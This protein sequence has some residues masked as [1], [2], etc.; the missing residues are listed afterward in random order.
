MKRR[1]VAPLTA[2]LCALV[3]LSLA[4]SAVGSVFKTADGTIVAR[5]DSIRDDLYTFGN[6]VEVNGLVDGDVLAFVYDFSSSGDIRGN[7]NVFT[8]TA[9]IHGTID[10]SVR[11][12][13]NSVTIGGE[14]NRD[15]LLVGNQINIRKTTQIGRDLVCLG[16]T[17]RFSGHVQN[18]ATLTG[19][20]VIISGVIDGNVKVKAKQ[21]KIYSPTVIKGDLVYESQNEMET[22]EDIVI[23]GEVTWNL[24][25]QAEDEAAS[26]LS[27]F[28]DFILF[29][30]TL[31]TGFILILILKAHTRES[32][33][34][35][36]SR[37]GMTFAVGFITLA[38][39]T[40]GAL[41]A[42]I[43]IVGIPVGV[44][45][46]CLGV[47]LFYVGKIY[48]SI[49]LGRVIFRIFRPEPFPIGVEL[50]IGLIILSLLFHIPYAGG[51]IYL[52]TVLLGMGAA[53]NGYLVINRKCH[54]ALETETTDSTTVQ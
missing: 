18:D 33:G 23:E 16:T 27:Y 36:S 51:L 46:I 49:A 52:L 50:I 41:I 7:I 1:T 32:A 14:I 40:V 8:Y 15:V 35:I 19:D 38:V 44:I 30:L 39:C 12:F 45:L 11:A 10:K 28:F 26:L 4:T 5:T 43:L 47:V 20:N 53:V 6:F 2:L 54:E 3:F 37:P 22:D 13:A 25:E 31:T 34:Q 24:P 42:M 9:D 17:T 29:L 21:L 48:V